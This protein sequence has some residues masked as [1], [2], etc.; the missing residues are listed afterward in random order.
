[1]T[2]IANILGAERLQQ[3]AHDSLETFRSRLDAVIQSYEDSF[4]YKSRMKKWNKDQTQPK[5]QRIL[6]AAA[7]RIIVA[8][9][10]TTQE[11]KNNVEEYANCKTNFTGFGHLSSLRTGLNKAIKKF[12]SQSAYTLEDI[13]ER[14]RLITED[15]V[16]VDPQNPGVMP[17][18]AAPG[19]EPVIAP[20]VRMN[21]MEAVVVEA[22]PLSPNALTARKNNEAMIQAN[23]IQIKAALDAE[24]ARTA[25]LAKRLQET[26]QACEERDVIIAT[27][28]QTITALEKQIGEGA[29]V[30]ERTRAAFVEQTNRVE[31]VKEHVSVRDYIIAEQEDAL[32][33]ARGKTRLYRDTLEDYTKHSTRLIQNLKNL[34]AQVVVH[35]L[36]SLKLGK[37]ASKRNR[38]A[39]KV[40]D[41]LVDSIK[42]GLKAKVGSEN[43]VLPQLL[44]DQVN[45]ESHRQMKNADREHNF[46]M[47]MARDM[48]THDTDT[49]LESSVENFR[50]E[51]KRLPTIEAVKLARADEAF[52]MQTAAVIIPAP[53]RVASSSALISQHLVPAAPQAFTIHAA[54][55]VLAPESQGASAPPPP[56]PPP[57]AGAG[58]ATLFKRTLQPAVAPKA[59]AS[60]QNEL[61]TAVKA[62]VALKPAEARV[63]A[64]KPMEL[65]AVQQ[66]MKEMAE[67]K[68]AKEKAKALE[69]AAAPAE[70]PAKEAAVPEKKEYECDLSGFFNEAMAARRQAVAHS[71]NESDNEADNKFEIKK[72]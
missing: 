5:H 17:I 42:A 32:M 39:V 69:A 72:K 36:S 53:P 18:Q 57:S 6:D 16:V 25:I 44:L 64:A 40:Q 45:P 7:L 66:M 52:V 10:K 21:N 31:A 26:E 30:L 49:S 37:M 4:I 47:S 23:A 8:G 67:K 48:M 68:A 34:L 12:I 35:F 38:T 63:I 14:L 3:Q 61:I 65:T 70:T 55:P 29:E 50:E 15:N 33:V 43:E 56:P 11:L 41:D 28:K 51:L 13:D 46:R 59:V 22:A 1:M 71:D 54:P 58:A 62:G 24:Q 20:A 9:A 2:K 60:P 27:Q 19:L